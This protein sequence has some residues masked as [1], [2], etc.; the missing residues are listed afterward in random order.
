[1]SYVLSSEIDDEVAIYLEVQTGKYTDKLW[2]CNSVLLQ[3][4]SS[5]QVR[6]CYQLSTTRVNE[7]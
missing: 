7:M 1:M 6:Y 5:A 3:V 4:L 2:D